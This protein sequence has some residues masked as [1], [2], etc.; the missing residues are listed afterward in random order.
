MICYL[1]L[2]GVASYARL[3]LL[4][5]AWLAEVDSDVNA[6]ESFPFD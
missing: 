1:H 4:A 3:A 2:P 6:I 5:I